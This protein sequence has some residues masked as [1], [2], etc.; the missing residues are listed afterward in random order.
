MMS[1]PYPST[2]AVVS[3]QE[4]G[5]KEVDVLDGDGDAICAQADGQRWTLEEAQANPLGHPGCTRAFSPVV[6]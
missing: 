3:Y 1:R 2:G 4:A 5:I 6:D